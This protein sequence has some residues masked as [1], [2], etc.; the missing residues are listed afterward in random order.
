[1]LCFIL[2]LMIIF[3]NPSDLLPESHTSRIR[4]ADFYRELSSSHLCFSATHVY[5][6]IN[7]TR[8]TN[9]LHTVI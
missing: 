7:T 1:M 2:I 5:S 8:L 4:F 3:T 9:F 6:Y